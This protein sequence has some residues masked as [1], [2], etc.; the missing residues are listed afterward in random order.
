MSPLKTIFLIFLFVGCIALIITLSVVLTRS[1]D[2]QQTSCGDNVQ[3]G[4]IT[5]IHVTT[6]DNETEIS[7]DPIEPVG[8]CIITYQAIF[9]TDVGKYTVTPEEPSVTL[10]REFFC[11]A[12]NV[13]IQAV[14][15][16]RIL[17]TNNISF[18][19]GIGVH[20]LILTVNRANST[21]IAT[22]SMTPV[23]E[24][25]GVNYDV[26]LQRGNRI[27][28]FTRSSN[29]ITFDLIYCVTTTVNVTALHENAGLSQSSTAT[30]SEEL[31]TSLEPA[32]DVS[33][34]KTGSTVI[35]SWKV[36]T[37]V[38]NCDNLYTVTAR[39][40]VIG[41]EDTCEGTTNC[42][43]SLSDFCPLTTFTIKPSSL[44]EGQE[45]I[46]PFEC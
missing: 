27:D 35:V 4:Y 23:E 44:L 7:W 46:I 45:V 24:R 3:V 39:N 25:C 5:N 6:W 13:V 28:Y 16:N 36:S 19:Y 41:V 31:P 37:S 30:V 38:I 26:V 1:D 17:D 15:D 8:T 32:Q 29:D 11:F 42:S 22:W 18:T 2:Q 20:D 43:V 40:D 9:T 34:N 12:V 33:F 14:V 21:V 10:S